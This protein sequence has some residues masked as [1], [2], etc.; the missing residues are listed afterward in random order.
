MYNSGSNV[1]I[2]NCTFVG[3]AAG[4]FGGGMLTSG[5]VLS[6]TN[7]VFAGNRARSLG[8]AMLCRLSQATVGNCTM[9]GNRAGSSGGGIVWR[10]GSEGSVS[11]SILWDNSA[12]AGAQLGVYGSFEPSTLTVEHCLMM[13]GEGA[14]RVEPNDGLDWGDGNI[15]SDPCFADAGHWDVNG[16]PEDANDDFWVMGDYHLKS[17]GGR[18]DPNEG[19]PTGPLR[20]WTIDE[21]TS[22]CIDGGHP[23]SPIGFEPFPNGGRINMGAYG[24]TSEASKSYFGAAPCETIVA[25]DVNGD[26]VVN[27]LDFG[28]MG[29]HWLESVV[30]PGG[31][32]GGR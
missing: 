30:D 5:G 9:V 24:G 14:V 8:G 12:A 23:N 27:F 32:T 26:C 15:D 19:G 7:C 11:D 18:W 3:N 2:R 25:G 10:H 22:P 17:Q 6:M 20:G 4:R 1:I 31:R 29:L 13:G 21:V 16:T 28:I